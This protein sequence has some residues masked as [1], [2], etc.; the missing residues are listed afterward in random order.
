VRHGPD[1]Q[2]RARCNA[3]DRRQAGLCDPRKLAE[4]AAPRATFPA[5]PLPLT[6]FKHGASEWQ[7][8]SA[9][10]ATSPAPVQNPK[11]A[12]NLIRE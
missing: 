4:N 12:K 8:R 10:D 2:K 7:T 6:D 1:Q 11:K 3:D 5:S 9:V